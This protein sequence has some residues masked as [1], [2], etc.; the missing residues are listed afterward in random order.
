M[1]CVEK[2]TSVICVKNLILNIEELVYFVAQ[3][4][5]IIL[6]T[7]KTALIKVCQFSSFTIVTCLHTRL[8]SRL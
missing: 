6:N 7:E 3:N 5:C 4:I 2:E 8:S 1:Q